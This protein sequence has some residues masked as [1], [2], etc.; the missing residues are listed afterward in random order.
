MVQQH[1]TLNL[2]NLINISCNDLGFNS[3]SDNI[4]ITLINAQSLRSKEL[5]LYE[6]IRENNIEMCIVTETWLQ[7]RDEDKAWCDISA[8]NN[9]NLV[10]HN[11]NQETH[12][13]GSVA[14]ISKSNLTLTTQEIDKLSS[15]EA[16]KWRVSLQRK[17]ITLI[18]IYRPPYSKDLSSDNS[19]VH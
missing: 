14:L 9:D 16:A 10:L 2:D 13:G 1:N 7:N 5:L 18:M 6:Y 8:F 12:R 17:N 4:E 15:F 19:N 3:N 11:I